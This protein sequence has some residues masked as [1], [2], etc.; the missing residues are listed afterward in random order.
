MTLSQAA[1]DEANGD[2][3]IVLMCSMVPPYLIDRREHRDRS[4]D[5]PT[6]I[7]TRTSPLPEAHAPDRLNGGK[8]SPILRNNRPK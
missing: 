4:D 8:S 7:T 6:D 5:E 2:F 3:A 1:F